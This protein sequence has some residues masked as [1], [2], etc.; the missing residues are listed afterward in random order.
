MPIHIFCISLLLSE[1]L[2][3]SSGPA[4]HKRYN[5]RMVVAAHGARIFEKMSRP[6]AWLN[7]TIAS[8]NKLQNPG[9]T[10]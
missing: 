8:R 1:R 4:K 2:H 9:D 10:P 3:I 7:V 6:T 5:K